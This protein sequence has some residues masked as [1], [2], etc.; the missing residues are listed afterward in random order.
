MKDDTR[1][2]ID[3]HN[4][5]AI[6][7]A[8]VLPD[9]EVDEE[10]PLSEINALAEAAGVRVVGRMIQQRDAP[11]AKTYL[12]KGK[13]E[14]LVTMVKAL[15]AKVVIFDN[16]LSP[17]QI[18]SL[19][20]DLSCKVLDRSELILDIFAARAATKEAKL[21]VEIAQLEYTAPRLRAMW[22]HLG[23]VTGGAPIGVGTRGPGEQQ[24]EI[25]RRLVQRRLVQL[26]RN[27][28]EVQGRKS[29]EVASRRD[30]HFTV[31]LVGYTNAGKSTLF[32]QMT[33]GDSFEA[34]M[35]FATLGT[36][37]GAWNVGGGNSVVLSDT[38]GFI[39]S[40]PH[41]LVASFRAT[42]EETVYAHV[43]LIVLD[44]ADP[45]AARQL[46]TVE[47]VLDEIG[48]SDQPRLLV[49]NK[50]DRLRESVRTGMVPSQELEAWLEA[51]P[52]AVAVS[53]RTGEGT[54]ELSR[55][56]LAQVRGEVHEVVVQVPL[57]EGKLVDLIEKR[58]E[59]TDRNYE[60][61]GEVAIRTTLGRRQVETFL[62]GGA[63]FKIENQDPKQ[64][65]ETIWST[66]EK[67]RQ[68]R[69]PPHLSL[70]PR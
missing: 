28:S 51:N 35:L 5:G 14:E 61:A 34:D 23:Q 24:L 15:E 17:M 55:R 4:E 1:E 47:R 52:D 49:L 44:V 64:A 36:R 38:V 60:V 68:P 8:V 30:G 56:I 57:S 10:D 54:E 2:S 16:D 20:E 46:A 43:L 13:V 69:I 42:L 70:H 67:P 11:R 19:E 59:V 62:A 50:V 9:S 27:L 22:S 66:P 7:V 32:N 53:A 12:G 40:L 33:G 39:R 31:G 18:R 65:L 63:R 48:A 58:T 41:H 6:T 25:D 45:N 37:V 29:R 26:K 3:I 21:A